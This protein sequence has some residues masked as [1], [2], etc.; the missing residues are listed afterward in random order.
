MTRHITT[1][2]NTTLPLVTIGVLSYNRAGKIGKTIDSILRQNY[3]N[4]EILI[5]D[6]AS[7]DGAA[8]VCRKYVEKDS[9]ITF[10]EHENNIGPY[11][12]YEFL[13]NQ[14]HGKYFMWMSDDDEIKPNII[15]RY[16]E[17]L[18]NNPEYGLV[19]GKIN[20]WHGRD[21]TFVEKDLCQESENN[22]MRVFKYYANV[23]QGAIFYGLM[24]TEHLKRVKFVKNKLAGDWHVVAHM[25]YLSK[26]KQLDLVSM[27]KTSGGVFV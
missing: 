27:D 26:I 10:F 22:L 12:N 13:V 1:I 16:V 11:R 25:A 19:S 4:I 3:N 15:N 8:D 18:E 21:L 7:S 5:S 17:F 14:A 24:R 2:V 9:R 23:R 20:Y 6:D